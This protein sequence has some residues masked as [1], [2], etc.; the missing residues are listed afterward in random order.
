MMLDLLMLI[1]GAAVLAATTY[2]FWLLGKEGR[3]SPRWRD[4][5][6]LEAVWCL[7]I[8]SGWATG[9]SLI[10]RSLIDLFVA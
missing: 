9:G 7:I 8:L 1:A 2:L 3:I 10:A 5:T 4:S 6:A